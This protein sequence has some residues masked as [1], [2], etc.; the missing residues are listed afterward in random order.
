MDIQEFVQQ[1]IGQWRSQRS[2]HHLA[3]RH[4][5]A[6]E[7]VIDITTVAPGDAA[8]ADLC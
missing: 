8:V 5:E 4:F 3:F 6:I 7:S 1:S 2:A